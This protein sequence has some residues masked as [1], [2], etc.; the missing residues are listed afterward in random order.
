MENNQPIKQIKTRVRKPKPTQKELREI[1][2][3]GVSTYGSNPRHAQEFSRHHLAYKWIPAE[4]F[5]PTKNQGYAI[6]ENNEVCVTDGTYDH[7]AEMNAKRDQG[8]ILDRIK[9]ENGKLEVINKDNYSQ[10]VY[11]DTTLIPKTRADIKRT[12]E[13][14]NKANE[15]KDNNRPHYEKQAEL[16]L[17][18]KYDKQEKTNDLEKPKKKVKEKENDK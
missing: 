14:I 2:H 11:L 6:N 13:T 4:K 5:K 10:G 16:E 7:Q 8:N 18:Q 3:N 9:M 17:K 1:K 12:A 15:W